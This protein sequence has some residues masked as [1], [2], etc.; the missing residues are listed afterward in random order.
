[1]RGPLIVSFFLS[2]FLFSNSISAQ[3]YLSELDTALFITDTVRPVIKRFENLRFSG[4][5][6]SQYQV[7]SEK[8][9]KTFGGGDFSEHSRSRFMLRRA[10]MKMDYLAVSENKL[11]KALFT[12][13]IDATERSVRVRDMFL[14][15]FETKKNNFSLTTGVFAR[16]FGY[17]VNLSS[18]YRETPE[19]G[20]MSQILLPSERD[21]GVMISYDPQQRDG[22][23]HFVKDGHIHFIKV[24]AGIFN[25]PGLSSTMDFD[26]KKDFIGR[27]TL[28][29]VR[30]KKIEISGSLSLIYG[31]WEQR[32]KFE[33]R[34][35]RQS[36]GDKSFLVDSSL[37]NIGQTAPRHYYGADM[38]VKWI[39]QWGVS[40]WR[41]EYWTGKNSGTATS[42]ANP[43]TLPNVPT[44]IRNFNGAFFYF[45]QDIFNPKN[46]VLFKY[47]WYDPNIKVAGRE[48]GKPGTN[49]FE[50]DIKFSTLG[51]GFVR[52]LT[53]N[54][55]LT[56]YYEIVTNE[57]TQL[58]GYTT[59]IKDNL[60]TTRLQFRF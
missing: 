41:A 44:Y 28:K 26:S 7:I 32:S 58:T 35:A 38:Q 55:K 49:L 52:E 51:M 25:G 48:I 12:F 46:Q 39:H 45:L 43:G 20:R 11:P 56:L 59:D 37:S 36:S 40:E 14:R 15:I 22:H 50:G 42:T 13:Q 53:R 57:T 8:G 24:D 9:A 21:L 4:Y 17:E 27:I 34:L 29:P 30:K 3:R 5:L 60:F 47:D 6:Q 16:P 18:S 54:V 23:N 31:G 1:M 33:Y 2:T 10:R 19:R